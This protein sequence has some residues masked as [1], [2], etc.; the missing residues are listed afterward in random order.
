[1]INS[2]DENDAKFRYYEHDSVQYAFISFEKNTL[3]WLKRIAICEFIS[4][5][6]YCFT[7]PKGYATV[8]LESFWQMENQS[9]DGS[10]E[11]SESAHE[12]HRPWPHDLAAQAEHLQEILKTAEAKGPE[13]PRPCESPSH[14][15]AIAVE[16]QFIQNEKR[17]VDEDARLDYLL[18][19]QKTLHETFD[20]G[21]WVHPHGMSD[22]DYCIIPECRHKGF[23]KFKVI[24]FRFEI[25]RKRLLDW[26]F[27][28]V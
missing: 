21:A 10:Q 26:C 20:N 1:M 19:M 2:G 23:E 16:E 3:K 4:R 14:K 8:W 18:R 9:G 25:N 13:P 5:P 28:L 15:F 7:G 11:P 17:A 27:N 22:Y 24:N 6:L 12:T